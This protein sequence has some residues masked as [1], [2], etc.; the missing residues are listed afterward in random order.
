M[1]ELLEDW[2]HIKDFFCL[3]KLFC[4]ETPHDCHLSVYMDLFLTTLD[5]SRIRIGVID[6]LDLTSPK[7]KSLHPSR[8]HSIDFYL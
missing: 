5:F 2:K 4:T 3:G 1:A 6:S 7:Y 8:Y